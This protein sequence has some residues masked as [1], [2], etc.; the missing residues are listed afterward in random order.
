MRWEINNGFNIGNRCTNLFPIG[1]IRMKK[2]TFSSLSFNLS[3]HITLGKLSVLVSGPVSLI[4]FCIKIVGSLILDILLFACN[5]VRSTIIIIGTAVGNILWFFFF[6]AYQLRL[7]IFGFLMCFGIIAVIQSY[8]FIKELPSPQSIGKVNFKMTSYL[9]DKNG[10]LLYE[11]YRDQSRTPVLLSTLP[12]Y[13]YNASIAIEDKDF[14][15]HNGVS[16]I[17]GIFRAFRENV[18]VKNRLQ[19]GSTIT[20]QL[21]KTSLLS[22]ERTLIRKFREIILALW[23]ERVY[24][25]KEILEM[26]LNQIPYGGQ[27][28]GIEEAAKNYF[29]KHASE[30]TISESA[31]LAGLTQAPSVYSPHVNPSLARIRRNEV[32][33]KMRE[34]KYI[35]EDEYTRSIVEDL[36]TLQPKSVIAAPHFVFYTK[37]QLEEQY[38]IEL[39]EEGGLKV[40]TTLD[41]ALQRNIEDIVTD[42]MAKVTN[43]NIGNAAV[44]VTKPRTGEILSMV[45]STDYYKDPDGAYNVTTGLRQPGS[46]FKPLLYSLAL[47]KGYT[48]ASFI[49]DTPTTFGTGY[50]SYSPHNYDGSYHG[51][52][53]I[54]KALANS[55]NIPAVRTLDSV[56]VPTYVNYIHRLGITT[57]NKPWQQNLTLA[58]GGSE[59]RMV[60]V[61]EAYSTLANLGYRVPTTPITSIYF[62]RDSEN[63]KVKIQKSKVMNPEY[64][65]IVNDILSDNEARKSAFGPH[66]ALEIKGHKV[67]V[68]TG[69]TD[70]FRDNWTV[71][72]TPEYMVIVWVGN[73]NNEPMNNALTSGITGAAPIWNRVMK[74]L[75]DTNRNGNTWY[76]KPENVIQKMCF[77]NQKEYFIRGTEPSYCN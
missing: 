65:F 9:Y 37:S 69:T 10:K 32:L 61:A 51:N 44:L 74:L 57:W 67:A 17:S 8:S 25:K 22:V 30:L 41:L 76:A 16:I 13:V 6:T 59:V 21:I 73:N 12:S 60:E 45:G 75:L 52:V 68:K 71:G 66:S 48:A 46:S 19:G 63:S 7:F 33:K 53:T 43:L 55:Y 40:K 18:T 2:K 39:V 4:F 26:Y 11:L 64:A 56:G 29:G 36:R 28:Y 50:G 15:K 14:Y 1:Y 38:G 23:A 35:S 27:S 20:Q 77:G 42:E 3:S 58:L 54:R 24:T 62:G 70:Q 31:L 47:Q 5:I 72:Y 34:Q 49:P